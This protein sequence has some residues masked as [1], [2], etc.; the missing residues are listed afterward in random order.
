MKGRLQV[1][2]SAKE[3]KRKKLSVGSGFMKGMK[4]RHD[5]DPR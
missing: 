3:K 2:E 1:Y 4:K 5:F